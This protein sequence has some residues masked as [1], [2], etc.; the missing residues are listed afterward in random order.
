MVHFAL[1]IEGDKNFSPSI[2]LSYTIRDIEF[3]RYYNLL[4]AV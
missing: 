4:I 2:I 3:L 1:S